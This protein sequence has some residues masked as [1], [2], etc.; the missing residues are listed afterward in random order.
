[1]RSPQI[2]ANYYF[3]PKA[4]R[5]SPILRCHPTALYLPLQPFLRMKLYQD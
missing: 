2:D 5:N 3:G 4:Y 1:M